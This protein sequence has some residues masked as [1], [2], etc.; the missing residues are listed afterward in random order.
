MHVQTHIMSG[1]CLGNLVDLTPRERL[2]CMLAA[3]LPDLDGA[4]VLFGFDAYREYHH[5]LGHNLAFC[6][7]VTLVLTCLSTHRLKV[8]FLFLGLI[9]LH[10]LMDYFG[11]GPLWKIY[12]F[13][14]FSRTGYLTDWAWEFY[15]WQNI[16]AAA[17]LLIWT[18]GIA[19]R[20]GR[21]PLEAIMP[22]LDEQLVRWLRQ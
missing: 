9:H 10:L 2:F 6:L 14:P 8:F 15:S 20:E 11:S 18:I 7:L 12:Y 13:W 17:V 4:A 21:T 22:R 5:L 1:W 3:T 16:S 19:V